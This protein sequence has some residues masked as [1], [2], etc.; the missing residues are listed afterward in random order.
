MVYEREELYTYKEAMGII[1]VSYAALNEAARTGVMTRVRLPHSRE[2]YIPKDE[3]D[4]L[5]GYGR[6]TSKEARV[7]IEQV[8]RERSMGEKEY[9]EDG[10]PNWMGKSDLER[11][12]A[13]NNAVMEEVKQQLHNLGDALHELSKA[14]NLKQML[15]ALEEMTI[16]A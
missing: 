13:E 2:L 8:R 16:D 1:G 4:A 9:N 7:K 5:K 12:I 14:K 10:T 6:V 11:V 3:V 15:K